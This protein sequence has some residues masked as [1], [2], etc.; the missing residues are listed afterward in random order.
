MSPPFDHVLGA[1]E[2]RRSRAGHAA[3]STALV[4]HRLL[5]RHRD[6]PL[7]LCFLARE[8]A[9]TADRFGPLTVLAHRGLLVGLASL[10]LAEHPLALH[11]LL[12]DA[13][14]LVD[15]VVTD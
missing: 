2:P 3:H 4:I 6:Q 8:L 10:H 9:G 13:E 5:L 14:R 11:L 1:S 15:V 7:A 12:Q